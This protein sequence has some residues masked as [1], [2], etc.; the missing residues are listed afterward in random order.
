[1][2]NADDG[3]NNVVQVFLRNYIL[4]N[5]ISPARNK[6]LHQVDDGSNNVVQVFLRDYILRNII[7]P[8]R[9]KLLHQVDGNQLGALVHRFATSLLRTHLVKKL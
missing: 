4:R 6:L 3:S 7:S 5:I 2:N 8:T 9:N 1:M